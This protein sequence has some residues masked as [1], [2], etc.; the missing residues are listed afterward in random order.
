MYVHL[1][2]NSLLELY[3]LMLEEIQFIYYLISFHSKP[4]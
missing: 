2:T 4:I 3:I 1:Y